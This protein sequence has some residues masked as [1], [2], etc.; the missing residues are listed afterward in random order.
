MI[1]KQTANLILLEVA[2]YVTSFRHASCADMVR[3]LDRAGAFPGEATLAE[4]ES[5]ARTILDDEVAHPGSFTHREDALRLASACRAA[6]L[7][8]P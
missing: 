2:P 7:V 3:A 5:V 4:I 6:G 1:S 8:K